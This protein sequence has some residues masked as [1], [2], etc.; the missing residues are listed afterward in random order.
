MVLWLGKEWPLSET[1]G[2]LKLIGKQSPNWSKIKEICLIIT[3]SP[4][5]DLVLA[6]AL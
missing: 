3:E 5:V 6:M 1:F 2:R 4:R